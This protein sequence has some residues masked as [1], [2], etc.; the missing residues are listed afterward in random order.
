ML[1][2]YIILAIVQGITEP[3]PISS[4]GHMILIKNVF[5]FNMLKDFNYEIICNFG[6]FLAIFIIFF[7]DIKMLLIQVIKKKYKYIINIIISTL[8]VCITGL[9]FKKNLGNISMLSL[10]VSFLITSLLLFFVRNING[11]KNDNDINIKDAI[12]IGIFQAM[13]I[14]PGISRCGSVLVACLLCKLKRNT[15]LKYTFILY[16]PVSIAS[17]ILG[18]NSLIKMPNFNAYLVP[19]FIGMIVSGIITLFAYNWLSNWLK[20][21]KIIYF[22]LYAFLLSLFIFIYFR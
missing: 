4:S 18:V 15:A 7:N 14:I 19:Y 5:N 2:K 16:F 20:N 17:F 21:G 11:I 10:G 13:A 1:I 9:L 22:S 6:S 3:L 8:P 12:I